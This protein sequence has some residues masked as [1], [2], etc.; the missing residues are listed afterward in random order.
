MS[1][2]LHKEHIKLSRVI[3]SRCCQTTADCD[4]IVPD[5][6][7]DVL[8]VLR[9]SSDAVITQ[10]SVQTDKI[11]LQGIVN[12]NILYIPDGNA[13]GNVKAISTTQEFS[14]NTEAHGVKPGMNIIAE[15]ECDSSE[16][17]LVNS[18][19]LNIRSLININIK[20]S[21]TSE[22]DIATG[23]DGDEPIETKHG[24]LKLNNC[25]CESERD[26]VLRNRLEVP[27]GNPDLGEILKI[28]TKAITEELRILDNK[29]ILRGELRFCTLYCD[30]GEESAVHCMEH[31][32]PFT[33]VLDVDGLAE[34][35]QAEADILTKAIDSEICRDA[36]GDK[37]ILSTET[38]LNICV[39]ATETA[40]CDIIL[41]AYGTA[42]EIKS[43][44][45]EHSIEQLIGTESTTVTPKERIIVPD[46][47]PDIYQICDCNVTSGIESINI[48][49]STVN[50]KGYITCNLLYMSGDS[51]APISG[52]SHVIPF[53]HGFEIPG[54]TENAICD[55]KTDIDHIDYTI[56]SPRDV[57]IRAIITLSI[58]AVSP[59]TCHLI[60]KIE[61]DEQ[62]EMSPI[63]S[64]VVYFIQPGDTLWSIAKRYRTT[65]DAL[66]TNNDVDPLNL[67][68]G[69]RIF[70]FR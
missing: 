12:L 2:K 54:I 31:T 50:I 34:T 16:H 19:K 45:S 29:L 51:E 55:A 62:C 30:N 11:H 14:Y 15:A 56:S 22:L 41:D 13:I 26:I 44:L 21:D 68:I 64:M 4:I 9:V 8:K 37:R 23:I 57:E 18:R 70:I 39:H 61:Y 36:D 47:L 35:M 65:V 46:Y 7:P 58:K 20:V 1:V 25:C 59:E 38:T 32:E 5:I 28:S 3:F 66:L 42:N 40:E 10:K 17:S 60:T 6:K 43:E 63:P 53:S 24:H 69:S 67:Q 48:E 33:E 27:T 52:F 49:N